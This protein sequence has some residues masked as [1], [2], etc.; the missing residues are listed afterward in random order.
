MAAGP[1]LA[2]QERGLLGVSVLGYVVWAGFK[3]LVMSHAVGQLGEDRATEYLIEH[4]LRIL[5]RNYRTKRGEIDVVADDAGTLCFVE[6]RLRESSTY[7]SPLATI[8]AKKQQRITY[9]AMEYLA[10]HVSVMRS[11][12][13]RFDV[14][15]I[16]QIP[17]R[18]TW[19]KNAFFSASRY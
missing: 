4:G 1:M 8:S 6:V 17:L 18:V 5:A 10:R 19:I 16:E 11:R 7:G 2:S 9:A 14:I 3:E 13:C 15:S 12:P